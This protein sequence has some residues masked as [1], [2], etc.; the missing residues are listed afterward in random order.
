MKWR[1]PGVDDKRACLR[2]AGLLVSVHSSYFHIS[3]VLSFYKE[4][5]A[6]ET[7]NYISLYARTN[8]SQLDASKKTADDFIDI[9]Y[10]YSHITVYF[11][12]PV[13]LHFPD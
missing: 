10:M 6:E 13:L 7:P 12:L 11:S 8:I 4:E 5:L 9:E 3:D 1:Y 2:C